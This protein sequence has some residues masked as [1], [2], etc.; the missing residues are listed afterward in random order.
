MRGGRLEGVVHFR[1][2]DDPCSIA[3]SVD[4]HFYVSQLWN[5]RGVKAEVRAQLDAGSLTR[6]DPQALAKWVAYWN[7][8]PPEADW[9]GLRSASFS[10]RGR[11]IYRVEDGRL[12]VMVVW[13]TATHDYK[14]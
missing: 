3:R 13:I 7:D 6:D 4:L 12:I 5:W 1:Q 10:L 11:I 2:A 8:H 14:K 9:T